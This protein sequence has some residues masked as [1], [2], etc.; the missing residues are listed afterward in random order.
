MYGKV[1][2][3]YLGKDNINRVIIVHHNENGQIIN[4]QTLSYDKYLKEKDLGLHNYE[5]WIRPPPKKNYP[6][7]NSVYVPSEKR[8]FTCVQCSGIFKS[9]VFSS[10]YCS[11]SC[12]QK[13]KRKQKRETIK[14]FKDQVL[15][16]IS[17]KT[18]DKKYFI[19]YETSPEI[20]QS[21]LVPKEDSR[22]VV[23]DGK[24]NKP[25]F[26]LEYDRSKAIRVKNVVGYKKYFWITETGVLISRRTKKILSQYLSVMGYFLHATRIG[27]RKGIEKT[28]RIHRLVGMAFCDIPDRHKD[29][30]FDELEINHI[31]GNKI[32]NHHTNLEWCNTQENTDHAWQTGLAKP[33]IGVDSSTSKFNEDQIHQ[34]DILAKTKTHREISEMFNCHRS[35]I[36]DII[37]RV[38]YSNIP[39]LI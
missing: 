10:K 16:P 17:N 18:K 36:T 12:T 1:H 6:K 28:F 9:F 22:I 8:T 34:I 23:T 29:K 13:Y 19:V 31:D 3:P 37:N 32:N 26:H 2:G 27:G 33:L 11:N 25:E 4:R 21:Y 35:T 38:S 5:A 14:L 24:D 15:V 7:R 30:T 20:R 39:K